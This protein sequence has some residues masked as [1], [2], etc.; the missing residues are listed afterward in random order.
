LPDLFVAGHGLCHAQPKAFA[1]ELFHFH[2][3]SVDD[4]H[5]Q[6]IH[7]GEYLQFMDGIEPNDTKRDHLKNSVLETMLRHTKNSKR[8]VPI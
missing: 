8:P 1:E 4:L 5:K 6:H 3:L 2:G 7:L